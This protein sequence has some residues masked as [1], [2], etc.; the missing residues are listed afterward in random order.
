M[1]IENIFVRYIKHRE[2]LDKAKIYQIKD[3][4]NDNIYIGSTCG[5]LNQRLSRHKSD[6]KRFLKGLFHNVKSFD[7]LK[8]NNYKIELLENCEIKTKQELLER[9]RY[10][11]ETNECLNKNIPGRCDK[12]YY[13]DN[14]DKLK[15]RHKEYYDD[16]K[17]KIIIKKREYYEKNKDKLNN[18]HKEYNNKNKDKLNEKFDCPCGGNYSYSAKARHIKTAKHQNFLQSLNK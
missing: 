6:Y 8:N 15:N 18:R 14:K 16:N 17:D 13:N 11:I 10:Y 9:E 1:T 4:T 3:N 12:Q 7:I 2:R 5:S